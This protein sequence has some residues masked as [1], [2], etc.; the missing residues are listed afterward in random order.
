M[1]EQNPWPAP[2]P[3]DN[4]SLQHVQRARTLR[5][6]NAIL[7]LTYSAA[8]VTSGMVAVEAFQQGETGNTVFYGSASL[9]LARMAVSRFARYANNVET[10]NSHSDIT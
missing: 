8:S 4:L 3:A 2:N 9:Y 7:A 6:Y 10:I 1:N 5:G